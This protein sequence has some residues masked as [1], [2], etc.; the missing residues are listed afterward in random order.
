MTYKC[1]MG[2]L[3]GERH[4]SV[5][6][7]DSSTEKFT[8]YCLAHFLKIKTPEPDC[9]LGKKERKKKKKKAHRQLWFLRKLKASEMS[10]RSK[11]Q[12]QKTAASSLILCIQIWKTVCQKANAWS[13][14]WVRKYVEKLRPSGA[15]QC[16]DPIRCAQPARSAQGPAITE[17]ITHY[18][19]LYGGLALNHAILLNLW[20]SCCNIN[21]SGCRMT[22][23]HATGSI[24]SAYS[25][26]KVI[27]TEHCYCTEH[28]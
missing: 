19:W 2:I 15:L 14:A 9:I 11:Q 10:A 12:L 7:T 5:F 17:D 16:R 23:R 21:I 4:Q 18:D 3:A 25:R 28:G 26:E 20:I 8:L 13:A 6:R 27:C 1:V 22:C 24:H